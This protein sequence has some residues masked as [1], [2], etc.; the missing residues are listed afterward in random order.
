MDCPIPLSVVL[1]TIQYRISVWSS[2]VAGRRGGAFAFSS[3]TIQL[4]LSLAR[5][6]FS[7]SSS[8][9]QTATATATA[10]AAAAVD[11][12]AFCDILPKGGM[13]TR[14]SGRSTRRTLDR[15]IQD[16][17]SH[18]GRQAGRLDGEVEFR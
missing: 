9:G 2:H 13:S 16:R 11:R 12:A 3:Q 18:A 15:Q 17:L 8:S 1:R 5:S 4:Y 10:A 7:S 6:A 14:K